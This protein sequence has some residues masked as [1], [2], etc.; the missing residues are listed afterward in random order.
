ME[1]LLLMR[2]PN[3]V[4]NLVSNWKG[5]VRSGRAV[6]LAVCNKIASRNNALFFLVVL[7]IGNVIGLQM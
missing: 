4:P 6:E 2:W 1:K 3:A 5:Y 7:N